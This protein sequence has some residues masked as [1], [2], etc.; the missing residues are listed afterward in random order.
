MNLSHYVVW[1]FFLAE[2][3]LPI[4][5]Q[6]AS[7]L[8]A[9]RQKRLLL[10]IWRGLNEQSLP[11]ARK[12]RGRRPQ[13]IQ[14]FIAYIIFLLKRPPVLGQKVVGLGAGSEKG[15]PGLSTSSFFALK[16]GWLLARG[17][18]KRKMPGL[19]RSR[20]ESG[21]PWNRKKKVVNGRSNAGPWC[22]AVPI[23]QPL[24]LSISI[25]KMVDQ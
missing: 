14:D 24:P 8:L 22:T 20:G 19:P 21:N 17:K 10:R 2:H 7:A 4:S 13:W 16:T 15:P 1:V 11:K 6:Q 12:R 3:H 23:L 5:L 18:R 25:Q 9:T